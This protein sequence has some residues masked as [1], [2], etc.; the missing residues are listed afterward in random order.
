MSPILTQIFSMLM[1]MIPNLFTIEGGIG[2][3]IFGWMLY[4]LYIMASV[5]N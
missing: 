2:I 1:L 5:L 3:V 4:I